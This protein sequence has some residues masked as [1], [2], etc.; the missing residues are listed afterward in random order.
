MSETS[1]ILQ[2]VFAVAPQCVTDVRN[3]LTWYRSLG[4]CGVRRLQGPHI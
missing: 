3:T 1:P 4:N 2:T